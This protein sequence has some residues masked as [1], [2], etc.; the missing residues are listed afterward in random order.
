MISSFC[1]FVFTG[2]QNETNF[3]DGKRLFTSVH[4]CDECHGAQ[5]AGVKIRTNKRNNMASDLSGYKMDESFSEVAAYVRKACEFDGRIDKKPFKG[6]DEELQSI[7]DWL[8][9]LEAQE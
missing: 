5:S 9:S 4:S 8:G 7:I 6:T 1:F 2:F 3:Y